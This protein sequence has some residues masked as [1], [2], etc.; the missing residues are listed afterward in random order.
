MK[1]NQSAE[2]LIVKNAENFVSELLREKLSNSFLYHNLS[3][4]QDVVEHA[5]KIGKKSGLSDDEIEIVIIAA[6][7]HD[8]GYTE[9]Y[10]GHE[11]KSV[12][13]AKDFLTKQNYS[14]E[15]IAKVIDCIEATRIPQQP[16]DIPGQV[17]CDSDLAHLGL[18]DFFEASERLRAEWENLGIKTFDETEWLNAGIDILSSHKFFTPYARKKFQEQQS[19][20][21]YKMQKQL[22][23]RISE[24][25]SE[26]AKNAKLEFEKQKL[27]ID[28][29][30][31]ELKKSDDKLGF[32]KEKFAMKK[33]SA[34]VAERGIETMFRNTIRTHVEFSGMADNKA[35][36]MISI[37][38]L[39][40][41]IIVTTMIRKLDAYPYLTIPTFMLLIVSLICI[42][43]A[44]VVTRPKITS[45]KFTQEE[46]KSKKTNLLFFGNFFN[47]QLPDFEWG[48][49]EMMSD[50][51]YLY[52]SMIKD[53]YFLGQAV[54]K[55]YK[56]LR[57]CYTF[58]MFGLI[59]AVLAYIIAFATHPGSNLDLFD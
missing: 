28:R 25:E 53:F 49:K 42:I 46:I 13:I 3:H 17:I 51:D 11:D 20:N 10:T 21:L 45:G 58:F 4:T 55:K 16:K 52:G 54:G 2:S 33:E 44:V 15:K 48:M 32:E 50:K 38:T 5:K 39:I 37:N 35:N 29:Q 43:F 9:I 26:K 12:E 36:I 8:A 56:Y 30:K 40:I 34:N 22:K 7:F 57:V 41:G 24:L 27:D 19:L 47:M 23:K 59:A 18:E 31:I 1:D 6:W 14:A